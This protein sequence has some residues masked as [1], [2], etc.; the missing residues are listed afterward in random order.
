MNKTDH[1]VGEPSDPLSDNHWIQLIQ[2]GSSRRRVEFCLDNKK[3][4]CYLRAIQGD[5]GGISMRPEMMEYTFVPD[6]WKEYIFH[7]GILV[8]FPIY[9]GK[10]SSCGRKRE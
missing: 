6:N 10:W 8:E 5:T 9:F 7:R 2:Q 3:S 4:L 1:I